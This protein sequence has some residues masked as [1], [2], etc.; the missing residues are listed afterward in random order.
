MA[1]CWGSLKKANVKKAKSVLDKKPKANMQKARKKKN[2][3]RGAK[4]FEHSYPSRY[5]SHAAMLSTWVRPV[6][7]SIVICE[8]ERGLYVTDKHRLDSG[9]ADPKRWAN[10]EYRENLYSDIEKIVDPS[11]KNEDP[12]EA[13]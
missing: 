13:E 5:G 1:A 6:D 8:V 3:N 10:V 4:T 9:I 2:R 7:E 12:G 11:K